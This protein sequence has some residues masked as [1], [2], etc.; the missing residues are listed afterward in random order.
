VAILGNPTHQ[1]RITLTVGIRLTTNVREDYLKRMMGDE[2]SDHI[3]AFLRGWNM[4]GAK[5]DPKRY[6]IYNGKIGP[7]ITNQQVDWDEKEDHSV[8]AA[9]EIAYLEALDVARR[10][11]PTNT[12]YHPEDDERYGESTHWDEEPPHPPRETQWPT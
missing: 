4:A 10:R 2:L 7:I 6:V 12:E 8:E 11:H 3:Q 5:E 1:Q 9:D